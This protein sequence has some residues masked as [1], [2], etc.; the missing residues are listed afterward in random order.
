MSETAW[1]ALDAELERWAALGLKPQFWLRDDDA[2]D[3][4]DSL[5]RLLSLCA[6]CRIPLALAVIPAGA[7]VQLA[8]RLQ[9]LEDVSVLQHGFS[10]ANHAIQGEKKSEFA[11]NR[12]LDD[13]TGELLQ[14]RATLSGLFGDAAQP[15]LVPPW[16]RA[17]SSLRARRPEAGL[18]G[19]SRYKAR[20]D[21]S[22]AYG[23]LEVNTHVDL[24][25][26]RNDRTGAPLADIIAGI[27][28]H[29]AAKRTGAADG[30]EPTGILTHHLV[31]D[32]TAWA[33]LKALLAKLAN[34]PRVSW[35]SLVAIF[36]TKA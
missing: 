30:D 24:I 12:P 19:L 32:R 33:A 4:T 16:T 23:I 7:T 22:A 20:A 28:A 5:D 21:R 31:M 1:R 35:P 36:G 15:V 3:A 10:H 8:Q 11:A 2:V 9:G 6:K 25:H 17:A 27:A 14:A 34:D 13:M 18:S 29:L 26:W